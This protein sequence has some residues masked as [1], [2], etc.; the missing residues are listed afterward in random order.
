MN[1]ALGPRLRAFYIAPS[2]LCVP[3]TKQKIAIGET[4]A[5]A[6]AADTWC[7]D[8]IPCRQGMHASEWVVDA[9]HY[10]Y[11]G[12]LTLVDL[13]GDV[14][15]HGQHG[16]I[17]KFAARYRTTV[18]IAGLGTGLGTERLETL[19]TKIVTEAV[20]L[21][22]GW[23]RARETDPKRIQILQ[24]L[25]MMMRD[26]TLPAPPMSELKFDLRW[27][28]LVS[29]IRALHRRIFK[30]GPHISSAL[31]CVKDFDEQYAMRD[32]INEVANRLAME[33]LGL[34]MS[35]APGHAYGGVTP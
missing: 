3:R 13:H 18:A 2:D 16:D 21:V 6:I 17:D 8:V 4:V 34:P 33:A 15:E 11:E 28:Y 22:W 26:P 1:T 10:R 20:K 5:M 25:V 12:V 32:A 31:A 19:K 23:C 35:E 29:P 30:V 7:T 9:L 14:A 24:H 27:H